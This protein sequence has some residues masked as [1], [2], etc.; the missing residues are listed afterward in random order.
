MANATMVA[1]QEVF[2][3][4]IISSDCG[5][6]D[7]SFCDFYLWVILKGKTCKNNPCT[8]EALQNEITC[9]IGSITMDQLQK[10]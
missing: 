1:V 6:P 5:L 8:T 4:R 2:E 9:I 10:V 3:D 7:L